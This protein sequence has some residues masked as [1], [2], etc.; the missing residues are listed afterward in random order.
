MTTPSPSSP[1]TLVDG[2]LVRGSL[3]PSRAADFKACPLLYRLRVIDKLPERP[4][5]DAVRGTVVHRVL[6]ELFDLP[7]DQR[8]P[9]AAAAMVPD[10]WDYVRSVDA[11]R[12]AIFA[13][14][15]SDAAAEQAWLASCGRVLDRYFDLE[16][17]QRL[18]PAEREVY[19]EAI[20]DSQL[21]LRGFIDRVD[22][23]SDGSVRIVDYKTGRSPGEGSEAKALFQLRFYALILWHARGTVPRLL[24]LLYLGN[25][26]TISY[27]PDEQ[28]LRATENLIEALW[29]AIKVAE[30]S[31]DWRPRKSF[32]CGWCSFQAHCPE[33]GGSP[34]PL[35]QRRPQIRH[36]D[37]EEALAED[38]PVPGQNGNMVGD[39]Q[40]G[41]TRSLG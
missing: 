31:G 8:T 33:F 11:E 6:E 32:V 38:S 39:D 12:A 28:D 20:L 36:C 22:V 1:R 24:Q 35:P 2:D 41:A 15:G 25:G 3:S 30:V 13:E 5:P 26:V 4:S 16:D 17:P 14:D 18:E 23:A 9:T 27:S 40:D 10:A 29:A 19:V 34:P 21:L 7:A 37:V